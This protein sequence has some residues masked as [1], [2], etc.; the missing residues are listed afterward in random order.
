M[1]RRR[2]VLLTVKQVARALNVGERTVYRL[3]QSGHLA[4]PRSVGGSK[5]WFRVD[6]VVYQYRL[7]RGD[8]ELAEGRASAKRAK[9]RQGPQNGPKE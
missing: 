8:F 1:K 7:Q 6:V 4:A 2:P 9:S 5:R 3:V